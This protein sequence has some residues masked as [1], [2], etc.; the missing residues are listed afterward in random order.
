MSSGG[1]GGSSGAA[2][3]VPS[4]AAA[5]WPEDEYSGRPGRFVRDPVTGVRGPAP[6]DDEAEPAQQVPHGVGE[7]ISRR[8]KS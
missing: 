6:M 5:K 1:E 2:G 4:G 8:K 3:A 7:A